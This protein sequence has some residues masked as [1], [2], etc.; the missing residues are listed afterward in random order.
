MDISKGPSFTLEQYQQWCQQFRKWPMSRDVEYLAMGIGGEAGEVIEVV[1]KAVRK[2]PEN[3]QGS[4]REVLTDEQK[5][6]IAD[7][8]MDVIFYC[9][10]L[11]Y[12]IG[13]TPS[14]AFYTYHQPKLEGRHRKPGDLQP[15]QFTVVK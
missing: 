5:S 1:K 9:V 15:H 2:L 14:D 10:S 13:L 3:H 8:V 4:V 12:S 7:E 11:L 6:K